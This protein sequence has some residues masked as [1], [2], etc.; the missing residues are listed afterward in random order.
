MALRTKVC[1]PFPP[2]GQVRK[3]GYAP[4]FAHPFRTGEEIPGPRSNRFEV[5]NNAPDEGL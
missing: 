5:I 3:G 4:P 2:R 1:N